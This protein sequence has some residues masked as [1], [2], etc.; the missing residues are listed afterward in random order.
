LGVPLLL[1]GLQADAPGRGAAGVEPVKLTL[2]G[3]K[4]KGISADTVGGGLTHG[5]TSRCR[6]GSIHSIAPLLKQIQPSLGRAGVSGCHHRLG[7]EDRVPLGRVGNSQ[8]AEVQTHAITS[9]PVLSA[10]KLCISLSLVMKY[11][12]QRPKITPLRMLET[13]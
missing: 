7:A 4:R 9:S 1:K 11:R 5:E 12:Y 8:P 2:P 13:L 10:R 6:Q 3:H